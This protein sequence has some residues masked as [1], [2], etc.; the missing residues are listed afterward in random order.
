M[1]K[2]V[3]LYQ[4]TSQDELIGMF[5]NNNF[6]DIPERT[7][8]FL[9]FNKELE[10]DDIILFKNNSFVSNFKFQFEMMAGISPD[11]CE[12]FI[13]KK[14]SLSDMLCNISDLN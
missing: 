2:I 4:S 12:N 11:E 6:G 3:A 10:D 1:K 13:C 8:A 14:D 5:L 9:G 7:L